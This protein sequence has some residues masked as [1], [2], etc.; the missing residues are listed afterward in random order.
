[1]AYLAEMR[2]LAS[3]CAFDAYR[4]RDKF[5]CGLH[6]ES[7][8]RWALAEK[9][10]DF[11]KAV[12]IA[13]GMEAAAKYTQ[14]LK[15]ESAATPINHVKEKSTKTG[16]TAASSKHRHHCNKAR[17][18]DPTWHRCHLMKRIRNPS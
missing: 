3:T 8:Q 18:S 5:A 14:L 15:S 17:L 11:T 1:M 4:L 9:G 16:K 7:M 13:Q 2:R 6:S 12:K 10:L